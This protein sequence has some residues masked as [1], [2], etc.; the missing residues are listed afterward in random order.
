MTKAKFIIIGVP[1]SVVDEILK[2]Q[3]NSSN[4]FFLLQP[5]S[6]NGWPQF[7][8]SS[9]PT[10]LYITL[11]SDWNHVYYQC[12]ILKCLRK[13]ELSQHKIDIY[14]DHLR[15]FQRNELTITKAKT[16][17]D[18]YEVLIEI[19][20]LVELDFPKHISGLIKCN[21]KEAMKSRTQPNGHSKVFE[22]E[23][24]QTQKLLKQ[25]DVEGDLDKNVAEFRHLSL[26]ELKKNALET[27]SAKSK[28]KKTWSLSSGFVR[29]PYVIAYTLEKAN[30]VCESCNQP[31]PFKKKKD[32]N[33]FLEVHH[34]KMLS[35]GG[36]DTIE[37]TIALLFLTA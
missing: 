29:N 33:P 4:D 25:K 24:W 20:P 26:K 2:S 27:Q 21:D 30:G 34:K 7:D 16:E 9:M 32:N 1:D 10:D 23:V 11:K 28:P 17:L 35:D 5:H 22:S 37:N 19:K 15:A 14:N 3:E 8:N 6:K 36:K 12:K 13:T 31:A 18:P